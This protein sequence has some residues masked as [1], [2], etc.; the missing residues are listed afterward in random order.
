[1]TY[2]LRIWKDEHWWL[3]GRYKTEDDARR[4]AHEL[5][6]DNTHSFR[7]IPVNREWSDDWNYHAK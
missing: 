2:T 5:P 7:I 4:A 3:F 1:M 6:L